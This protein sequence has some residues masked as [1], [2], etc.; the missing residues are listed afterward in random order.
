[1]PD[2]DGRQALIEVCDER[3]E[4]AERRGDFA[5]AERWTAL[6]L[7]VELR[8]EPE[9]GCAACRLWSRCRGRRPRCRERGP[10]HVSGP[11]AHVLKRLAGRLD[12]LA[13]AE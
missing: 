9:S 10:Q 13:Q 6:A 1:M 7:Q 8:A 2:S 5:S 3:A 11:L 12:G 4:A